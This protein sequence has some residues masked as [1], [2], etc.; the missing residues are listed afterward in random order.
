MSTM[1]DI[2]WS[3]FLRLVAY[4]RQDIRLPVN[5]MAISSMIVVDWPNYC[6]RNLMT[7]PMMSLPCRGGL[8]ER[9]GAVQSRYA[10]STVI[11]RRLEE[12][13]FTDIQ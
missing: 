10:A 1:V 5:R 4:R 9:D 8:P 2:A 6:R 13:D 7:L 11:G 3:T 12:M